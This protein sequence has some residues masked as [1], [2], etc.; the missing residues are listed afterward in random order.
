MRLLPILLFVGVVCLGS[1]AV[2]G[3]QVSHPELGYTLVVP[4]GFVADP[5]LAAANPNFTHAF[6]RR[7]PETTSAC[8]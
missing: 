7:S 8:C 2:R 4:E 1:T 3:E 5:E 6:R